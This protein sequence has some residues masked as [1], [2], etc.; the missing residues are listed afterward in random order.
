MTSRSYLSTFINNYIPGEDLEELLNNFSETIDIPKNTTFL[1]PSDTCGFL[2]F[3]ENGLF[4]VY[5][6]D[7]KGREITTWFSYEGMII[8]DLLSFYT[9]NRAYFYVQ[10]LEDCKIRKI[11]KAALEALYQKRPEYREFGRKFAEES[12]VMTMQRLFSFY[13]KD[14]EAHYLEILNDPKLLQRTPLK[15]LATYIGVTDSSLSRIRKKISS[16]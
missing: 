10:A 12:L 14:A 6:Y 11:T 4:R 8:T 2:A 16:Y 7:N 15:H 9:G 5:F 3:I 13:A 1:S